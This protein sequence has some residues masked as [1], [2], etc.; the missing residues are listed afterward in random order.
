[1]HE[2]NGEADRFNR[3]LVEWEY[4]S[5]LRQA[6]S[7]LCLCDF[8]FSCHKSS[9]VIPVPLQTLR[10][11]TGCWRGLTVGRICHYGDFAQSP[12]SFVLFLPS[13][14]HS[15]SHF[16]S[17]SHTHRD[18]FSHAWQA[19]DNRH[20]QERVRLDVRRNFSPT[21]TVRHWDLL[22]R[23]GGPSPFLEVLNPSLGKALCNLI[24]SHCGPCSEAGCSSILEYCV[25]LNPFLPQRL[26][27]FLGGVGQEVSVAQRDYAGSFWSKVWRLVLT[28]GYETNGNQQKCKMP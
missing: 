28:V 7:R 11:S 8:F 26:Q 16:E 9:A 17:Y 13:L 27:G 4:G 22:S 23:E 1:M 6:L 24:W 3:L 19:R 10:A 21:R 18:P 2:V 5:P 25:T 15:P 14:L 12:E 20:E